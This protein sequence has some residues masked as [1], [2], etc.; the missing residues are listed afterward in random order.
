MKLFTHK[1]VREALAYAQAGGQALHVWMPYDYQ[2]NNPK[3]PS[4]FRQN[5]PWAHLL[6][7]DQERLE[8]TA[9]ALGVRKIKVGREGRRGQHIDL[10][11]GPLCRALIIAKRDVTHEED[12][13]CA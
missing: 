6:D 13:K 7:N 12:T 5:T 2:I 11:A 3:T 1:Q 4:V 8:R 9:R 10:C